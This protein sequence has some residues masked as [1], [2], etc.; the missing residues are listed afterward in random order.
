MKTTICFLFLFLIISQTNAQPGWNYQNPYP[1]RQDLFSVNFQSPDAWF[2][3]GE[4][5]TIL[6]TTD[7]GV[8]WTQQNSNTVEKLYSMCNTGSNACYAVGENGTVVKSINGG[9]TWTLL[10]TGTLE[11]LYDIDFINENTGFAS[12]SFGTIAK[13]TNAGGSWSFI[14]VNTI[15]FIKSIQFT[16]ENTGFLCAG[17]QIFKTT[18]TG[19]NW[20]ELVTNTNSAINS[21]FLIDENNGYAGGDGIFLKTTN[22]G[23]NWSVQSQ[24]S[25]ILSIHFADVNNGCYVTKYNGIY[26]T[27]NAGANW[28][29]SATFPYLSF[30]CMKNTDVAIAVGEYGVIYRM[31]D[32]NNWTTISRDL[33]GFNYLNAV[34]FPSSKLGYVGGNRKMLKT[35]NAGQNWYSVSPGTIFNFKS[36][37]FVDENT[38]YAIGDSIISSSSSIFKTTNGGVTWTS[39]YFSS[40]ELKSIHFTSSSVGYVS[41]IDRS[42][43]NTGVVYKTTDSGNNW[44]LIYFDPTDY[45]GFKSICFS[46]ENIGFVTGLGGYMHRTTNAGATWSKSQHGSATF[47]SVHF[48]S[49]DTG[50]IAGDA[51][52]LYWT[53]NAGAS[54]IRRLFAYGDVIFNSIHFPTTSTGYCTGSNGTI[55]KTTNSGLNWTKQFSK[56]SEWMY[57]V[58]F[59]DAENGYVAGAMGVILNTENGGNPVSVNLISSLVP[60]GYYLSQN[61]PNPFNPSTKIRYKLQIAGYTKLTLYDIMGRQVSIL[62]NKKQSAGTYEV[63]FNGSGF[64]SGVYFYKLV[65]SPSYPLASGNFSDTKRMLLI[66]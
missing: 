4:A 33:V 8:S 50:Y 58:Y 59:A 65:V 56:T 31:T 37:Y 51:G 49:R 7:E 6:K 44:S 62:V 63:E 54:W 19:E 32:G 1:T 46:D 17:D 38:G 12:G 57:S 40:I 22:A 27:T 25:N 60:D 9:T 43:V 45:W 10:N 16:T 36:L 24:S 55:L 64:A 30:V 48:P 61:Y 35:T 14:Y 3:T 39:R 42:S 5:G 28:T 41:G 66:K 18:N 29:Q 21:L 47:Y 34:F 26:L 2:V 11:E 13:T 52:S 23:L 15:Y 53:R 20:T